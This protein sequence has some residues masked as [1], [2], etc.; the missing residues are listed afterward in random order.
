MTNFFYNLILEPII[1]IYEIVYGITRQIIF[2]TPLFEEVLILSILVVSIVFN[3]LTYPLYKKA[4]IIQNETRIKK[5]KMSKWV[6]H[7]KKNFKGD[8]RYF[9]LSAYYKENNYNPID[10]LKESVSLLI[11]IPFFA[12][13][14]IFFTSI[15]YT[16][17]TAFG[18][19]PFG[20][21]DALLNIGDM[22]INILPIIMTI[23]NLMS[24]SIYTKGFK[25]KDKL[26]S[27]ILP[28]IFLIILYRSPSALV[29]YWT[30]NNI[31]SLIKNIILKNKHTKDLNEDNKLV[32]DNVNTEIENKKNNINVL[33]VTTS[34]FLFLAIVIPTQVIKSSPEEFDSIYYSLYSFIL[35][36]ANVFLGFAI[37]TLVFYH[38]TNNKKKFVF[39]LA[40]LNVYMILNHMLYINNVG[41]I[42]EMLHFAM[43]LQFPIFDLL[44]DIVYIIIIFAVLKIVYKR[45]DIIYLLARTMCISFALWSII[46]IWQITQQMEFNIILNQRNIQSNDDS[47]FVRKI[48]DKD[49][50]NDM[51]LEDLSS[52]EKAYIDYMDDKEFNSSIEDGS[53]PIYNLSKKGKNVIFICL[54]RLIGR[55]YEYALIIMPELKEKFDGFKVWTNVYSFAPHTIVG[56]PAM[57]G[58]Y[59]YSPY[60]SNKRDEELV[61]KHNEA[62]TLMPKVFSDEGYNVTTIDIKY[63]NYYDITR[64]SVWKNLPKVKNIHLKNSI[65]SEIIDDNVG[66]TYEVLKKNFIY[67]SIVKTIPL[68]FKVQV[69]NRGSYLSVLNVTSYGTSFL[70]NY[71]IMDKL[72]ELTN[73]VYDD[74]NNVLIMHSMLTHDLVKLNYPNF[75]PDGKPWDSSYM[76]GIKNNVGKEFKGDKEQ[77]NNSL[78]GLIKLGEYFD[79][80]KNNNIYNNTRIII[81]SDH[82]GICDNNFDKEF[83]ID[84][85]DDIYAQK[86]NSIL[87]YKDFNA[88]GYEER[89]ELMS[90]ADAPYLALNEISKDMKNPWTGKKLTMDYKKDNKKVYIIGSGSPHP[91][92]YLGRNKFHPYKENWAIFTG[93]KVLSNEGWSIDLN[94]EKNSCIRGANH[95]LMYRQKTEEETCGTNYLMNMYEC[96]ICGK[97]FKDQGAVERIDNPEQYMYEISHKFTNYISDNNDSIDK[98][99]TKTAR[100]DY[101][102]GKTNTIYDTSANIHHHFVNTV[103][104]ARLNEDGYIG[105]VCDICG[106]FDI[107]DNGEIIPALKYLKLENENVEKKGNKT[108]AVIIG[109][110]KNDNQ[111]SSDNIET[112]FFSNDNIGSA[113]AMVT[114]KKQYENKNEFD[115]DEPIKIDYKI[116]PERVKIKKIEYKRGNLVVSIDIGKDRINDVEIIVDD[117]EDKPFIFRKNEKN[118][119]KVN[120][121]EFNNE[122]KTIKVRVA[123]YDNVTGERLCSPWTEREVD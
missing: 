54:D 6:E 16:N 82:G 113:Y 66:N 4:D 93:D 86:F 20:A 111:I 45:F 102:C 33:W 60:E 70:Q 2:E 103:K 114:L 42:S 72:D 74:S 56:A 47:N 101:G 15:D 99:G 52:G 9:I 13:A 83:N 79:Y 64:E 14:Y 78:A 65:K 24:A 80:L 62:I 81:V 100:C 5:E 25:L 50:I 46:N 61:V 107:N 88:N 44:M 53:R 119:Y 17:K 12:A 1:T 35:Y 120:L 77:L 51:E 32:K 91:N 38:F 49:I 63:E 106:V 11:Q 22:S 121:A 3:M 18:V 21:E 48:E 28:I 59:E 95:N 57:Y 10:Q 73:I 97:C 118:E 85:N 68:M 36:T 90:N 112:K 108:D 31:I 71:A 7:I 117:K 40:A 116:V 58:G 76:D 19:I 69:Y 23:I 43:P 98:H 75:Y 122:A 89:D 67:Y 34:I 84:N 104:R 37:W 110:D 30:F 55:Y 96:S 123:K 92:Y 87:M 115:E 109:I 27:F 29:I 26:S 8:E 94:I 41:Y 105:K 39:I